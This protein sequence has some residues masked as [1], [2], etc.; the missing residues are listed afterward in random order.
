MQ[1]QAQNIVIEPESVATTFMIYGT[2]QG[3]GFVS[4]LDFASLHTRNCVMS[5]NLD[6]EKSDYEVWTPKD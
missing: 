2:V 4:V 5:D 1:V 3:K 6:D